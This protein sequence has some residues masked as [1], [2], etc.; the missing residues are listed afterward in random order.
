MIRRLAILLLVLLVALGAPAL[1]QNGPAGSNGNARLNVGDIIQVT[2]P[3]E[4]AFAQPLQIDREGRVNLPEVGPVD[5]AGLTVAQARDRVRAALAQSFRDLGRFNLTLRERR[6]LVSV[7]GFV[8]TPGPVE[9]PAGANVQQAIA[10]AGGLTQGAQLD[11]LQVRRGNEV[12]TFDYKRFLDTGARNILPTLRPLDEIFVP[13]SPLTGNVQIDFDARTLAAAGDAAEDRTSVR[14]FGEVQSAG[15]FAWRQGMT[16]MDAIIRAGGVTR[17]AGTEQVR[18]IA[19]NEPRSFNLKAFL[20]SGNAAMNPPILAGTTIFVPVQTEEVRQGP[21]VIYVMGEVARPGAFE[22]RP[23]TGFFDL[24]ANSGGPTRFAETRQI[25]IIRA[26]GRRVEPFDLGAFIEGGGGIAP[27]LSPGDAIF[28]PEKTQQT[29][30]ASWL[31]TPPSRAVRVLGAVRAPGRFEWSN[32]MS[33]L[34]L[35]AQAGGPTDRADTAGVQILMGDRGQSRRFDLRR[36]LAEGGRAGALPEIRAGYT[37][38]IPELPASPSDQRSTW[39]GQPAER[40][41]YIMG[42]VG[43]PGRYAFEPQLS[44]LDIMS[45]AGGP[46]AAADL[47]NIRVAHRGEGRDR[48]SRVNLAAYFESGDDS[49]LPRVRPGDVIFVPDRNRNWLEQ[50]PG[51]TVRVLGAVNRPGRFQFNDSMNLLDLLAEAGGPTRDAWQERIVVVNLSCCADQASSFD[52]PA[53]ARSGDITRL[54]VVRA[55]DTVYVP[56]NTQSGWRVFFDTLRDIIP[57]ISIIALIGAL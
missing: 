38:T 32:E 3:G 4:E 26:D 21:R 9:L 1:A 6:L 5:V 40:S 23:G 39:I 56:S 33:L 25:R 15:S 55:G 49:L 22:V 34:D 28:V 42:S 57:V 18:V 41:I 54:P 37:I 7:G 19:N 46:T 53:F 2:L 29:E 50:S 47:L 31:R 16:V 14:V 27:A 10:A 36:F 52:L 44:F 48:V 45:A 11:R 17:F 12:I 35:I 43:S 30:Q 24:L 8:R 20:D 13:A 51:S